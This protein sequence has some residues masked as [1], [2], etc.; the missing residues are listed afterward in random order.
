MN[1]DLAPG[2]GIRVPLT[3]EAAQGL[4]SLM[5]DLCD[6]MVTA[7]FPD[8]PGLTSILARECNWKAGEEDKYGRKAIGIVNLPDGDEIRV[9]VVQRGDDIKLDIRHWWLPE[10]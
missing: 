9:T 3:K 10:E 4:A 5:A 7:K 8:S 2:K 1:E 6:A